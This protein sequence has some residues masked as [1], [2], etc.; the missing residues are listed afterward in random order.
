MASNREQRRKVAK[1]MGMR[2]GE[3]LNLA[4][5]MVQ[6]DN[7]KAVYLDTGMVQIID[8]QSGKPLFE[9]VLEALPESTL[10]DTVTAQ[11]PPAQ[12]VEDPGSYT[13]EFD[14]PEGKMQYVKNG[15]WSGV[16]KVQ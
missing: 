16:R 3:T 4:A 6:F 1:N 5:I 12:G 10:P 2:P 7:G 15:N 9:E 8:K 14:T 13:V 11:Q